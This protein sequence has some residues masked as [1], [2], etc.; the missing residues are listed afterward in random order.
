MDIVM[1]SYIVSVDSSLHN[2][3]YYLRFILVR[4]K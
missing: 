2:V 1:S 4:W 3:K